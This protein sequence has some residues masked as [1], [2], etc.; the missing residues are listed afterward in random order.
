MNE[1]STSG[2][3]QSG[4]ETPF[5][6]TESSSPL[7]CLDSPEG[8]RGEE[9]NSC[10]ESTGTSTA[11]VTLTNLNEDGNGPRIHS[12]SPDPANST[13]TRSS[14]QFTDDYIT[15]RAIL[16]TAYTSPSG[17]S[18]VVSEGEG[19]NGGTHLNREVGNLGTHEPVTNVSSLQGQLSAPDLDGMTTHAA[20]SVADTS[21]F[22]LDFS[23]GPSSQISAA[24]SDP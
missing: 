10:P 13:P 18:A 19:S 24:E 6:A 12:P 23:E 17:N 9:G 7:Q 16:Q 22:P 14:G 3:D 15:M 4:T 20:S 8:G 2:G 1:E 5:S 21:E 11:S